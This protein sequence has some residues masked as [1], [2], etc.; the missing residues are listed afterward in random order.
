M[1]N[2]RVLLVEDE[3]H[4]SVAL[5]EIFKNHQTSVD[6]VYN[7]KDGLN[8]AMNG[9][10]DAILLDIMLPQM[11]G[12]AVLKNLRANKISTP[13]MFLT[14]K[15]DVQDKV[16]GLDLGADDYLTKPFQVDELK[17]RIRAITRRGKDVTKE[18]LTTGDLRLDQ[19]TCMLSCKTTGKEIRLPDKE[20]HIMEYLMMNAQQIVS[21]EQLA[22]KIWGYESEAEYNNVEVYISFT[23]KKLK[24]LGSNVEIKAVRGIGYEIKGQGE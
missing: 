8:Y 19:K 13:V 20:F 23:R 18:Q 2:M 24:F 6:A 1:E 3:E 14:A 7:G 10:Y 12:F 5:V 4:L 22:L 16:H 15:D 9:S 11:D 21:R 17:A